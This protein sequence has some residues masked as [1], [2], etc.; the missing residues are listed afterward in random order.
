MKELNLIH[1][2]AYK[3]SSQQDY[4]FIGQKIKYISIILLYISSKYKS[5]PI[6]Y[7]NSQRTR[8]EKKTVNLFQFFQTAD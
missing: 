2:D 4:N 8:F 7:A 5:K 3:S 6:L 1:I